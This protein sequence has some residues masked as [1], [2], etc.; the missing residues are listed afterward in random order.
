MSQQLGSRSKYANHIIVLVLLVIS[1][2]LAEYFMRSP[3]ALESGPAALRIDMI[4]SL[5]RFWGTKQNQVELTG[6]AP[7]LETQVRVAVAPGTSV[8]MKGW[9]FPL[10]RFV[11]NRHPDVKLQGLSVTESSSG[12]PVSETLPD[13]AGGA[14]AMSRAQQAPAFAEVGYYE[15]AKSELLRRTGQSVLDRDLGQGASLLLVDVT[16]QGGPAAVQPAPAQD[17]VDPGM[18]HGPGMEARPEALA[19]PDSSEQESRT[20]RSAENRIAPANSP[21]PFE[22][23]QLLVYLVIQD[24][25]L[26]QRATDA[27][28]STLGWD[29]NRGDRLQLVLLPKP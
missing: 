14:P 24:P 8:R 9:T 10:L 5:N 4:D 27:V 16:A 13:Q 19:P 20:G 26:T 21:R 29:Q 22:V 12:Q 1:A 11:A 23:K 25:A 7:A 17:R 3:A 15:V 18:P 2:C 6:P 28:K